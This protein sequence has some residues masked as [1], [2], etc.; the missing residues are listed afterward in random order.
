MKTVILCGGSGERLWPLS[1][2]K[3]PKQFV[4]LFS[5]ISLFELTL[6]RNQVFSN[7]FVIVTNEQQYPIAQ[8]QIQNPNATF[9]LE[10]KAKNTAPAIALAAL[11]CDPDEILLV[12]PSDHLI[13]NQRNYEKAV[14]EA[15]KLAKEDFLVTFGIKA[16]KPETGYGYIQYLNNDV[17][18]FKEK[19]D[20]KTAVKYL[21]SEDYLWNSGMFCFKAK[22]YL[23]QLKKYCPDILNLSEQAIKATPVKNNLYQIPINEMSAI[24]SE[25][26]DYAIMEKSNKVKV[27]PCDIDWHDLGSFESMFEVMDKDEMNNVINDNNVLFD[28]SGN[29]CMTEQPTILLGVNDLIVVQTSQGL[30]VTQKGHGQKIKD[31]KKLLKSIQG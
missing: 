26:I 20:F 22:T 12:L 24:P 25:S 10:S 19:P 1:S 15:E 29:L 16:N 3:L 11:T 13:K 9:I 17:L 2:P 6:Q 28:S 21:E 14:Q 23:E 4:P 7:H 8:R 18:E 30:L 5:G 27:I 31:A